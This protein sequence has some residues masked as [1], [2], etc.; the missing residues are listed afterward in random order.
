MLRLV[1]ILLQF[2][3]EVTI[4]GVLNEELRRDVPPPV[5][6]ELL[7]DPDIV[8]SYLRLDKMEMLQPEIAKVDQLKEIEIPLNE[9]LLNQLNMRDIIEYRNQIKK[10]RDDKEVMLLKLKAERKILQNALEMAIIEGR[11]SDEKQLRERMERIQRMMGELE[12][13]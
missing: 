7:Y 9:V 13:K 12:V 8:R 5:T 10:S 3:P 4:M 11:K 6:T 1:I 2:L